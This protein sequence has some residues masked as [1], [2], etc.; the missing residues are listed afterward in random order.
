MPLLSPG[1]LFR[2]PPAVSEY[3][4]SECLVMRQPA[5]AVS[6]PYSL[7]SG[8]IHTESSTHTP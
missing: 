8:R 1:P 7:K 4:V 6:C 5:T 3:I 2:I